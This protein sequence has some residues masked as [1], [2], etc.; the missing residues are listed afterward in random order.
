MVDFWRHI[1]GKSEGSTVNNKL[2]VLLPKKVTYRA[3]S[4]FY[5]GEEYRILMEEEK[6][7]VCNMKIVD[8]FGIVGMVGKIE[9]W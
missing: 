1:I 8:R 4:P 9:R 7:K 2:T 6:E 5:V 3:T